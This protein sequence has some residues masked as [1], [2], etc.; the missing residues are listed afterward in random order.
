MD[1]RIEG[2]Y[3]A[4][5][6]ARAGTSVLLFVIKDSKLTGVDVGGLKYDGEVSTTKTGF[7]CS[8]VYVIPPGAPL[9]TGSP[10]A[11][12]PQRIPLEF[13][14]PTD[15][16]RGQTIRIETPLGPLNARFEKLRDL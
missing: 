16:A 2:I 9:I 3:A 5:M 8:V 1:S 10:P 11:T 14:L 12:S 15:F 6:A 7:H 4:Y 13:D